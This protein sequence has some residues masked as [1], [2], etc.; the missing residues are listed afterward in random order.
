[1]GVRTRLTTIFRNDPHIVAPSA[2]RQCAYCTRARVRGLLASLLRGGIWGGVGVWEGAGADDRSNEK[3]AEC[4]E[5]ELHVGLVFV[6][7]LWK[8]VTGC[9][10]MDLSYL[11]ALNN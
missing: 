6:D 5:R 7:G 1:M 9:S 4:R 2:A 3:E 8:C 11:S 10:V